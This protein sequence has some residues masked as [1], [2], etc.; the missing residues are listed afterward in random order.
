MTNAPGTVTILCADDDP[1]DRMLLREALEEIGFAHDLHFTED[2]EQLMAYLRHEG[3]Y[4][5]PGRSPAPDLLLLDLNMPRLDGREALLRIRADPDLN[6]IPIVVMSTAD[7][8]DDIHMAYSAGANSFV[9]KPAS[10][11][12]LVRVMRGVQTVLDRCR[13]TPR[14]VQVVVMINRIL[15]SAGA[16][17][18]VSKTRRDSCSSTTTGTSWSCCTTSSLEQASPTTWSGARRMRTACNGSWKVTSPWRSS[19]IA[20]AVEADSTWSVRLSKSDAGCR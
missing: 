16:R 6:A 7:S 9:V 8:A 12:E 14:K 4:D 15:R 18:I 5:D 3:A 2:G 10:F 11:E 13:R 19:T 17:P 1:D 20:W